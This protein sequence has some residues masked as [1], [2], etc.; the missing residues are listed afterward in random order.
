MKK[1]PKHSM[2]RHWTNDVEAGKKLTF[3]QLLGLV[4]EKENEEVLT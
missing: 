2:T 1:L 4:T 3:G